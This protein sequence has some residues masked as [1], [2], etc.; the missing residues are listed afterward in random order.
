MP[1][2]ICRGEPIPRLEYTAEE[3][4]VWATVLTELE[5]LYPAHACAEYLRCYPLFRFRPD[6]VGWER[7]TLRAGVSLYLHPALLQLQPAHC[8]LPPGG[9]QCRI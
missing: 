2:H 7:F 1:C 9:R 3:L 6:E 8:I 5:R 4:R